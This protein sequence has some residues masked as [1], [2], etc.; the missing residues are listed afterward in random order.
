[1]LRAPEAKC[2]PAR[3][4]QT[5]QLF[6]PY[7][8]VFAFERLKTPVSLVSCIIRLQAAAV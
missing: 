8:A 7:V 6:I 4:R 5:E 1:M 3:Q 2:M